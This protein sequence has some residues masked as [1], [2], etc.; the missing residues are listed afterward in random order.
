MAEFEPEF[1]E[2]TEERTGLLDGNSEPTTVSPGGVRVGLM[3]PEPEMG[4]APRRR[5]WTW[6]LRTSSSS[7]TV[8]R[9]SEAAPRQCQQGARDLITF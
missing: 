9:T 8:L 5:F 3:E 1:E 4:M 2:P 6:R 7:T